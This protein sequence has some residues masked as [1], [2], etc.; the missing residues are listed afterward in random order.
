MR[1]TASNPAG[2]LLLMPSLKVRWEL[3]YT[4]EAGTMKAHTRGSSLLAVS[5]ANC[6]LVSSNPASSPRRMRDW[7]SSN[8]FT[9]SSE[10]SR[11]FMVG[12]FDTGQSPW[13]ASNRYRLC[14]SGRGPMASSSPH[15]GKTRNMRWIPGVLDSS[16]AMRWATSGKYT[17]KLWPPPSRGSEYQRPCNPK[18][19]SEGVAE[20]STKPRS[21][22]TF[23]RNSQS[24]L[25]APNRLSTCVCLAQL[26]SCCK[27]V[28]PPL[29]ARLMPY[30]SSNPPAPCQVS[31]SGMA[32]TRLTMLPLP[33]A[34]SWRAA[35]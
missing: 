25:G 4:P 14:P 11:V 26:R 28:E 27:R 12:R 9:F 29:A 13:R 33:T 24:C 6:D 5:A 16:P 10:A 3:L 1:R 7:A 30:T 2:M 35:K 20:M 18:S 32:G 31:T 34:P 22:E 8:S 23:A 15:R 21:K 19:Q 17:C